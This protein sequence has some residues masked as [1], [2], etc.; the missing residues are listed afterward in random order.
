R[1][2]EDG[3]KLMELYGKQGLGLD[4]EVADNAVE[5]GIYQVW[6]RLS[7]GRLK[8]FRSMGNWLQ[9]FR[10]YRR[11]E[12]GRIVKANDHLMDSTRYLVMSGL[13]R[14]KTKPV[15]KSAPASSYSAG[16]SMG[17]MG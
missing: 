8:V 6:M 13:A 14:A 11:D 4:I 10:L 1:S 3:R 5:A 7:T 15:P 2:Q 16:T 12:K 9:E 17:W